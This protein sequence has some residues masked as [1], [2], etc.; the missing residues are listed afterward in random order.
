MLGAGGGG[1]ASQ[2]GD[3]ELFHISGSKST[4]K[5]P[6]TRAVLLLKYDNP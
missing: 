6:H 3:L 4:K 2:Y 5:G 1:A